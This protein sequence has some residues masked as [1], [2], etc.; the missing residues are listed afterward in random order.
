MG[1][2]SNVWIKIYGS[3]NKHTGTQQLELF[4]KKGFAPG[5]TETFSIDAPDVIDVK[6][7]EVTSSTLSSYKLFSITVNRK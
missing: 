3:K 6:K 4:G 5:S 7:I 2:Q 1:T